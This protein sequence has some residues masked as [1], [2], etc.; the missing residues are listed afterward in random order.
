[1]WG[2]IMTGPLKNANYIFNRDYYVLDRIQFIPDYNH[3]S[4]KYLRVNMIGKVTFYKLLQKP[5]IRVNIS[6]L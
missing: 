5:N 2:K 4:Y 3:L 6:F 1:M